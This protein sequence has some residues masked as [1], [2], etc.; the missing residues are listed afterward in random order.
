MIDTYT[1]RFYKNNS[2]VAPANLNP[3]DSRFFYRQLQSLMRT[4]ESRYGNALN[5]ES[6]LICIDGIDRYRR[7]TKLAEWGIVTIE[8][9]MDYLKIDPANRPKHILANNMIVTDISTNISEIY[10][11]KFIRDENK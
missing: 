11:L 10:V 8:D 3:S 7:R 1:I 9:V 4:Y 2:R 6:I 5:D